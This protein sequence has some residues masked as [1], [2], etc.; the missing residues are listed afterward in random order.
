MFELQWY[1]M[2]FFLPLPL[3]VR[4]LLKPSRP[5]LGRALNVPFIDDFQQSSAVNKT[6]LK[7][8]MLLLAIV[9][10]IALIIAIAKPVWIGA[11]V[12]LPVNARN[13]IIAV[14]LSGSMQERDFKMGGRIVSRLKATKKVAVD[15]I[16]RRE[17][18]RIGLILFGDQAYLQAP[19]TSDRK[20][21]SRLLSEAA[22]GLAG[23]RTALGDAIGLAVKRVYEHPDQPHVL[24]L[25]TDGAAT[26]GVDALESAQIA[27][28]AKLKIYT[29]GIGSVS[30]NQYARRTDLD[31]DT[32]K[33]IANITGGQY[34]Q[35]R[36][37]AEFTAIYNKIDELEPVERKGKQW[38]PRHDLFH[39]PLALAFV[40]LVLLNMIRMIRG[41]DD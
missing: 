16:D 19:L 24:V 8:F 5:N 9:A 10:W 27:A 15:F 38:R 23:E 31:E 28:Q 7:K 35:A 14:D 29:V 40:L 39:W 18:D 41:S 1:W 25:M 22:L 36:N 34:F 26:V 30:K 11:P 2:L 32:L 6:G 17:G 20:T 4:W 21:V 37:T 12:Q 33:E 13:L 3:L